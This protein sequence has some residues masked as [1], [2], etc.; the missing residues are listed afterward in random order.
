[1]AEL[2]IIGGPASN[3][4]WACRIACAE[5]G[6]A[7][8]LISVM[9]HTPEIKAVHPL[10]K[11]P[12]M[13]H[14]D[15]ALCESRAIC[16][17]I[18]RAFDGPP[19]VPVDPL[20]AARCEQ[21]ISIVATGVDPVFLRQYLASYIFP[22][23]PDGTPNRA[24]IDAALPKMAPLF[25]VLDTAVA[26]TGHLVGDRFSLADAYLTP[27]LYY[28]GKM[29]E[30]IALLGKTAHLKSY[31]DRQLARPSVRDSMPPAMPGPRPRPGG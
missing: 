18:D 24:G 11:I 16:T 23:T 4:V 15:V 10:G 20:G 12:A 5:K 14:G 9:P 19:L 30:S 27:I 25:A 22:G 8:S 1:M 17:Y 6:V 28:M 13:R 26:K 7:Y 31:L 29:P 21:W 3:F 2:Q